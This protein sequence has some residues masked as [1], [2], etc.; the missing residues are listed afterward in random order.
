MIFTIGMGMADSSTLGTI[1]NITGGQFYRAASS[2]ELADRYQQI[3]RSVSDVVAKDST[4]DIIATRSTVNGTLM[5]DTQYI[6]GTASVTFVN[7]T[8][9]QVEPVIT[10]DDTNYTLSWDPGAINC[11]QIWEVKYQLK[12]MHGGLISPISNRSFISYTT[13]DD[14]T[15]TIELR[16]RFHLLPGHRRRAHRHGIARAAVPHHL[17]GQR[18]D[19]GPAAIIGELAGRL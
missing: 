7:G 17:T 6:P 2:M 11:N 4:M 15:G 18:D 5:N 9:K 14:F 1:A 12:A 10:C 16:C 13:S 19:H 8:S 3:F